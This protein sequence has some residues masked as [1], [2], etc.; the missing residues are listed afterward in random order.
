MLRSVYLIRNLARNPARTALT[1]VAVALP[2]MIF[3][4]SAAVIHGINRFLDNS[5]RQLRLAV[6]NKASIVNLLP[7]GH[8]S[9]IESL[10]PTH[11]RLIS[12]C[13]MRWFGGRVEGD[14]RPLSTLACH[15]DTFTTTFPETNLTR[16]EEDLWLR[17][18]QAL[19]V[20]SGTALQFGWKI[21]ARATITPSLP[22]YKPME[23]HIVAISRS[24][25]DAITNFARLDY[26]NEGLRAWGIATDLVGFYFVKC[27]SQADV[28]HFGRVIDEL[29]A[30]SPDA[31]QTQNEKAFMNEFITQQ[32]NLP[33]NLT[34]L[35]AVTIFV[36]IMAAANT[37]SMNFRDR[38]GELATL[39]ALGFRSSLVLA[40]IQSESVF[41]CLLG[42]T[43]GALIPYVA[44]THTPLREVTV[45][46][47]Q[48]LDIRPHVC[49]QAVSVSLVIGILAAIWP[50]ILA[51]RLKVVVA[52]RR[53]E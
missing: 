22:P 40:L 24:K 19:I 41:L 45:P 15:H 16:E 21:G 37:M 52:L 43:L 46:L 53:L 6:A 35:A 8:R 18:R 4:L 23:F 48:H 9:K 17:D 2:V 3:V 10:D 5:A 38:L 7:A 12:V 11:E 34:I 28:E 51:A 39:K 30:N 50:S 13:G 14:Q 29:F 49:F 25:V 33:R 31:T 36:A 44:F 27:A 42:G 1:C 26:Y 47:I 20:G 32:F